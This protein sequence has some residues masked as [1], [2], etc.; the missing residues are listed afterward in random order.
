MLKLLPLLAFVGLIFTGNSTYNDKGESYSDQVYLNGCAITEQY[1]T[2]IKLYDGGICTTNNNYGIPLGNVFEPR[3]YDC[4]YSY[5]LKMDDEHSTY[6]PQACLAA[7]LIDATST[8]VN[9]GFAKAY[10]SLE[11]NLPKSISALI[12]NCYSIPQSKNCDV[13]F[14]G[15]IVESGVY[16]FVWTCRSARHLKIDY[17]YERLVRTIYNGTYGGEIIDNTKSVYKSTC[18]NAPASSKEYIGISLLYFNSWDA[19]NNYM[20]SF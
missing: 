7:S 1:H 13:S 20:V 14:D 17:S 19:Y 11:A 5:H 8:E 15:Q 6:I 3:Y 9:D 2:S 16:A 10:E 12:Q 4:S 18:F